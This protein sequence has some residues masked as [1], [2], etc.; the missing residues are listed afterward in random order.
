MPFVGLY[1]LDF[2]NYEGQTVETQLQ[3]FEGPLTANQVLLASDEP[4]LAP[5]VME[6]VNTD[7]DKTTSIKS[8]RLRLGFNSDDDND[9]STFSDGGEGRWLVRILTGSIAL[10]FIGNL[11][12]DDNSEAFQPRPNPVQL[13]SSDGLNSLRDVELRTLAGELPIGHY[14]IADYLAMC[15]NNLIPGQQM[16]VVMNLYEEDSDETTSH[17]FSDIFLDALTFEKDVDT[18]EDCLTVLTK[19]LDAF[20]CFIC[21]D[22]D[23]WYIIRWD[24]YDATGTSILTHRAAVYDANDGSFQTYELIDL[25]KVIAADYAAEYEGYRLSQDNALRRFQRKAKEV[26]HTYKFELPKDFPC[27]ANFTR[28]A[29]ITAVSPTESH[30]QIDCWDFYKGPPNV[31]NDGTAYTEVR[32]DGNGYETERFAVL[33]VQPTNL[34]YYLESQPIAVKE[35]DKFSFFVDI[36]HDGQVETSGADGNY[37]VAQIRLYASDST[38]YTLDPQDEATPISSWV[39]SDATW[40]TN[41]RYFKRFYNGTEDDTTWNTVGQELEF[42]PEILKDGYITICLHQTKKSD[43][44]QT[45]FSN[46]KFDYRPLINGTYKTV[47]GQEVKVS[48][49]T[50]LS[51]RVIE[52]E[53][54]IGE[55]PGLHYKGTLKKF[56]GTNYVLTESWTD[57]ISPSITTNRLAW[58]IVFQWWN[59]YRKTRTVIE[60]DIQGINS[61]Q[62]FGIPGLIYRWK[63]SHANEGDKFFMLT[64]LRDLNFRTCGWSGVFV[65]TSDFDGDRVYTDDFEFK[66]IQ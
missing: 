8:K 33:E 19:I 66:F 28:G 46:I 30:F 16:R 14:T 26:K 6:S 1:T 65:E 63:I 56:D 18:R 25:T 32:Y 54:F 41:N 17:T 47:S 45:H 3:D 7:D 34:Q 59:Q 42:L 20:G 60:T 49:D 2:K 52:K 51:R 23:G 37:N 43:Q 21:Y 58:F 62:E 61:D 57:F 53:M 31:S 12:L 38:Y 40:T 50:N 64:S 9:V 48:D 29:L 44:F 24:E 22:H 15:L 11:V 13:I 39:A 36:R 5:A 55:S 10:P 4:N 27:N 35:G